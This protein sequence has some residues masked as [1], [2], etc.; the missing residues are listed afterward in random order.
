MLFD[1]SNYRKRLPE[2]VL[3]FASGANQEP[4]IRGFARLGIPVG[5]SV[6]HLNPAAIAALIE[7]NHPV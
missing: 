4:E 5:V 2:G 3:V 6:N 1:L 7:I